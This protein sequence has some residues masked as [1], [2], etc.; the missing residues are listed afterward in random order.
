MRKCSSASSNNP[1]L[2]SLR[3]PTVGVWSK[4]LINNLIVVDSQRRFGADQ[5]LSHQW[6][7]GGNEAAG[8]DDKERP[9]RC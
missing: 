4:D 8:A 7:A 2:K 1:T 5:I 3:S 9:G 6:V